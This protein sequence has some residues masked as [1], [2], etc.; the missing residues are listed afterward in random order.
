[1][2]HGNRY[3]TWNMVPHNLLRHVRAK[4]SRGEKPRRYPK[5]PGSVLVCKVVNG[6]KKKYR[7][8]DLLK[9]ET[10]AVLPALPALDPTPGGLLDRVI[11]GIKSA[12]PF[13]RA[14][15]LTRMD[16]QGRP[17][18]ARESTPN[19][20][21]STREKQKFEQALKLAMVW[22]GFLT[23]GEMSFTQVV[24]VFEGLRDLWD[25]G[26]EHHRRKLVE[27][28]RQKWRHTSE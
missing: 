21:T 5:V 16:R 8:V 22:Q 12:W 23:P 14:T 27:K 3:D 1:I 10:E 13:I 20:R 4:L 2:E 28:L 24:F 18:N 19:K 26:V 15:K 25:A 17:G 7:F 11:N 6:L 9:P